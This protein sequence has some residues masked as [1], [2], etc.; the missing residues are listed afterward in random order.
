MKFYLSA[1]FPITPP[2]ASTSCTNCDFA[3]PPTAGL[4]GWIILEWVVNQNLSVALTL[5][6]VIVEEWI[7]MIKEGKLAIDDDK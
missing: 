5:Q 1:I 2:S 4:H 7:S 3:G 6:A